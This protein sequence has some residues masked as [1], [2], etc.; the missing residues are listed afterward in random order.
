MKAAA[1]VIALALPA[2]V[3][4]RG[5]TFGP[6]GSDVERRVG[7]RPIWS[8]APRDGRVPA[9]VSSLLSR[10]LDRDAV[11]RIALASSARLQASYGML[12][13]AAAAVAEATVLGP[14]DVDLS[15]QQELDGDGSELELEVVQD[16]LSLLQLGQRRGI[17]TAEVRA[18]RARAV[19]E[20]VSLVARAEAAFYDVVAA[21]QELE[22]WQT[23]FD[24]SSAA[25]EISERQRAAGNIKSL[26]LSRQQNLR[27]QARLELGRA[28]V[29]VELRRERLNE[30]LGLSGRAT[31]WTV[32]R[33]LPDPPPRAP[34]LD[35]LE[36][37][38]VAASLE[39][40]GLRADAEAASGRI[41]YARIRTIVPELGVGVAATRREDGAW[42]AGPAL[43]I[44]LPIFDWQAGPR[45]RAHAQLSRAQNLLAAMAVEVRA[46]ARAARQ[47]TLAA[48]AE[49]RHLREVVLPLNERLLNEAVLQYNAMNLSTF[50]LLQARRDQV[51]A[52]RRYIDALRRFWIAS[53]ETAALGRGAMP[54]T[55]GS[56]QP[57]PGGEPSDGE[58]GE[59]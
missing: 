27:E 5:A 22:L 36:Q 21:E 41:G 42:E 32:A 17:A 14:T 13:V 50:E 58:E 18:A 1:V 12:G 45:A 40:T 37:R 11:V 33:R 2:C 55:L 56:G 48:Y 49:V 53:A 39:L 24:A 38:A 6:V 35:D 57:D 52:G 15:V 29:E 23:A 16:V 59:H 31:R 26:D 20:T 8:G 44:G 51:D 25:A 47:R 4:S 34:A 43:R 3:A 19:G 30:V 54:G 7:I 46:R 9:A 10:P 28:Q